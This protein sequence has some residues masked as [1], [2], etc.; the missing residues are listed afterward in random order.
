MLLSRSPIDG[1]ITKCNDT[2]SS[3]TSN[4]NGKRHFAMS[5]GAAGSYDRY[6]NLVKTTI[7]VNSTGEVNVNLYA[8]GYDNNG[9][10]AASNRQVRYVMLFTYLTESEVQAVIGIMETYLDSIG[11]GLY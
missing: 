8:C 6:I 1:Y 10:L 11:T 4:T 5:R 9:G 7:A 2:T 3:S